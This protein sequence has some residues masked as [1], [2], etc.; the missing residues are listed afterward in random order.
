MIFRVVP[1]KDCPPPAGAHG[2]LAYVQRF[3]I[4]PQMRGGFPEPASGMYQLKRARRVDKSIMGDIIP[5]DRLRVR[6]EL[7]PNFG[8]MAD[9]RLKKETSL[10][11]CDEFW[12]AKW[13]NKELFFALSQ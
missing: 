9:R 2:F 4:V 3:D 12:L 13:F 11:Y 10:D 7:T 1:W 6:V 5:L 8:K